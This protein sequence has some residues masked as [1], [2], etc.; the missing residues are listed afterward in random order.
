MKEKGNNSFTKLLVLN[1]GVENID[2]IVIQ[3]ILIKEYNIKQK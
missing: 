3:V 2:L 1:I